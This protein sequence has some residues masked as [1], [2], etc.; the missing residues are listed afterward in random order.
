[1][2]K[3]IKLTEDDLTRIVKQVINESSNEEDVKG[4]KCE[5][6]GKGTYKETEPMDDLR[7]TL[8]CSKC[9]KMVDRYKKYTPFKKKSNKLSESNLVKTIK[10]VISERIK[11]NKDE[12]IK[13]T[14]N[15]K[16]LLI[17]PLTERSSCKYGSST[18]WCVSG[19]E[20]NKFGTYKK[21]C[22]TVGMIMIKDPIIQ[23]SLETSKFAINVWGNNIEIYNELNK[24]IMNFGKILRENGFEN[25]MRE[26]FN[27]FINYHNSICDNK[28]K[29]DYFDR[30]IN[31]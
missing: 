19:K 2:K 27:D 28:V 12:R 15:E 4:K 13:L 23:E 31:R 16:F 29:D 22:H 9:D 14:N 10:K 18:K 11:V 26:V 3:V 7:G 5:S 30:N 25:E 8:H 21:M 6:C 1:M 20:N 17:I 24:P